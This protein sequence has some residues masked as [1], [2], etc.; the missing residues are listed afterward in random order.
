[1]PGDQLQ[2]QRLENPL[3]PTAASS[4]DNRNNNTKPQEK[5]EDL[6]QRFHARFPFVREEHAEEEAVAI[7]EWA[8]KEGLVENFPGDA[9]FGRFVW[10]V[11]ESRDHERLAQA[12]R[13]YGFIHRVW[14]K[15]GTA[16]LDQMVAAKRV[17]NGR[18]QNHHRAR[19]LAEGERRRY[20]PERAIAEREEEE[21]KFRIGA[22]RAQARLEREQEE[23]LTDFRRKSNREHEESLTDFARELKRASDECLAD[24]KRDAGLAIASLASAEGIAKITR[25]VIEELKERHKDDITAALDTLVL[26]G[27]KD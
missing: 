22:R 15:V 7:A 25:G 10:K 13:F 23:F 2:Q 14:I 26:E 4:G 5:E 21:R 18:V 16:S 19:N 1:M 3:K 27:K 8:V 20:S 9:D 11:V 17:L 12:H 24:M 6:I